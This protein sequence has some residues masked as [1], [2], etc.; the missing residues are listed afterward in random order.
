MGAGRLLT[1]ALPDLVLN[2]NLN[3]MSS[4]HLARGSSVGLRA[5]T[6][7]QPNVTGPA[8]EYSLIS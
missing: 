6:Y 5:R 7:Q 2:R 1:W 4:D 8:V 3:G